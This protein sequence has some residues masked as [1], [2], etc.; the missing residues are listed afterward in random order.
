MADGQLASRYPEHV[1][2]CLE[3]RR[4]MLA[5]A[6]ADLLTWTNRASQETEAVL[7]GW[8]RFYPE[9]TQE[10]DAASG[11]L[12]GVPVG[13]KDVIDVAGMPTRAGSRTRDDTAPSTRDAEVVARLRGLGARICGKTATTEFA[14]LDPCAATNPF[15]PAH[16]PGG[17]SSGSAA[18]V[19][20][21]VVPLALGTQTAGSVCRPAAWCG[22][23]AFKPSTGRTPR[24]GVEPFAP[25]FDTVGVF[26]LDLPLVIQAALATIDE[27]RSVRCASRLPSVVWLK[28][29]YFED[30]SRD[31]RAQRDRALALL[32]VAGCRVRAIDTGL[33]YEYLRGVHRSVM[34]YEAFA[35]HG[36]LLDTHAGHIGAH[37]K[38]LLQTGAGLSSADAVA[39][40][41]TLAAARDRIETA[42]DEH[43]LVLIPPVRTAAPAGIGSTGDAG[44]II[45]WTYAGNPLTV[46]PVGLSD[47]GL[48]LAVMLAGRRGSDHA[49]AQ[50]ALTVSTI[51]HGGG[52]VIDV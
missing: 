3:R 28:D 6:R 41:Q 8:V 42:V 30:L 49:A 18:L 33:D 37:W 15:N 32:R 11:P 13:V 1:H 22:T 2:T 43:D 29:A 17:S 10:A 16:T 25:S 4:Q 51:L 52:M 40:L 36:S 47:A 9:H 39:A 5:R 35:S 34:Q 46:L 26:G 38:G 19:G 14:Y 48:P 21:G 31:C 12:A 45:P 27:A 23:Y 7:Q 50:D 20:A 24:A 44:L